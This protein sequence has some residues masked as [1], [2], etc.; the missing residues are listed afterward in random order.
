MIQKKKGKRIIQ[1]F[2]YFLKTSGPSIDYEISLKKI[3]RNKERK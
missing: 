2:A 1:N 3:E